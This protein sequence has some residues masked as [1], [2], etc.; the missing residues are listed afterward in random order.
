MQLSVAIP[1]S[2]VSDCSDIRSKTE[3]IFQFARIAAIFQI[4]EILIYHD[5]F[6]KPV[7]ANRERRIIKRIL[8]Y[9]ECPQYLRKRLFPIS[10]DTAAVGALSPLAIPHHIRSK[11]LKP[12]EIREAAI[13]L[14][15]GRVLAD[16]GATHLLEV[17][18][19]PNKPLM[20]RT[21]RTTIKIIKTNGNFKAIALPSPPTDKY[22]GYSV[23][24]SATTIFKL[25]SNR[26]EMKIATS[27]S[28]QPIKQFSIGNLKSRH[29]IIAFGGP[30]KGIPEMTKSEGKKISDIFDACFNIMTSNYGT[31]SLRLEEAMMITFSKLEDRLKES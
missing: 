29:L 17:I 9:L 22:W 23:H 8:Q 26:R 27:R 1:D 15:Q 24:S 28:C 14:N 21:I 5:P 13:F 10:R 4:K 16:V 6:L 25:L 20:N 3:K 30:Y 11:E 19:P 31:R 12:N 7:R 18:S 2:A